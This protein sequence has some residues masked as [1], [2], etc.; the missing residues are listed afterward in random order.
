ME[1]IDFPDKYDNLMRIGQQVLVNQQYIQAK[2]LFERAYEL[3]GT[4]E[5]NRF[6]VLTLYELDDRQ[7][8]LR[9]ALLHEKE[10]LTN[11]EFAAFY[12]DLLISSNDFLYARKLIASADFPERFEHLILSKIQQSEEL[13]GQMKRQKIREI[14]QRVKQLPDEKPTTQ[15]LLIQLIEQLPYHEFVQ[16]VKKLIVMTNVHGLVR[17]K[18]LESLMQVKETNPVAFLTIDGRLIEIVPK[19]LMKPEQQETYQK[20]CVL[21]EKYE[22]EDAQLSKSLKE[23]FTIQSA[24]T[25]PVYDSYVNDVEQWFDMTVSSYKDSSTESSSSIEQQLLE[26]RNK[27]MQEIIVFT[28]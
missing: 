7:E 10:Y 3:E 16:T 8:A 15:L 21:A 19:N 1:P 25:Y 13:I 4:F 6:L 27:I 23:E 5:A 2:E 22:Q 28:A 14:Y 11:E 26:K 24:I 18:L 17:A 12:F 20:L 9:Q